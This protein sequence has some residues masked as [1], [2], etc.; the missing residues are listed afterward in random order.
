MATWRV[1]A[2]GPRWSVSPI[3]S[4]GRLPGKPGTIETAY[5]AMTAGEVSDHGKSRLAQVRAIARPRGGSRPGACAAPAATARTLQPDGCEVSRKAV[6]GGLVIVLMAVFFILTQWPMGLSLAMVFGDARHW[7]RRD[8][9]VDDDPSAVA[10][11]P[12]HRSR[13]SRAPLFRDHAPYRPVPGADT[14]ALH[15]VRAAA[16]Y[17]DQ[18]VTRE[19]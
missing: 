19:P 8:A 5:D 13:D 6:N 1:R 3:R 15:R 18:S 17:A 16:L 11:Q 9:A 12:G 10:A 7:L 14:L 2:T 4:P